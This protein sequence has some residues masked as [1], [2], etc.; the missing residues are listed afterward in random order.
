[1][2]KPAPAPP[3]NDGGIVV[4]LVLLMAALCAVFFSAIVL[5]ASATDVVL[6]K[7]KKEKVVPARRLARLQVGQRREEVLALAGEAREVGEV[8]A[9]LDEHNRIMEEDRA[10]GYDPWYD[11]EHPDYHGAAAR[12]AAG[13]AEAIRLPPPGW[14]DK[15]EEPEQEPGPRRHGLKDDG[16]E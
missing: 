4:A 15:V 13:E 2:P 7:D 6:S 3:A 5:Y 8:R 16:W 9:A 14:G 10:A 1:M 12:A 11:P